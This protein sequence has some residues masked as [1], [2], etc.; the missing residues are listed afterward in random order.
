MNDSGAKMSFNVT[1]QNIG[2]LEHADIRIGRFTVLAGRNNTGKSTVSK[3]LYSAF[4]AMNANHAL[5]H[6]RGLVDALRRALE[7]IEWWPH[8]DQ[9]ADLRPPWAFLQEELH[10]MEVQIRGC[11]IDNVEELDAQMPSLRSSVKAMFDSYLKECPR[12][13]QELKQ[14]G[15]YE[16]EP[17]QIENVST[18]I[19]RALQSLRDD[20]EELSGLKFVVNGLQEKIHQ[21]LLQNFQV[22]DLASLKAQPNALGK[23]VIDGVASYELHR[24]NIT[25]DMRMGGL[26]RLQRYSRVL[27]LESPVHW[28]LKLALETSRFSP[29]FFHIFGKQRIS[30]VPAYVYDLFLALGE[31]YAGEVP[32]QKL[33]EKLTSNR[34]M[35]GKL[36]ISETGELHFLEQNRNIPLSMT[37]MGVINLGILALLMER[38]VLDSGT[39]LFIDEPESCLH[40]TWQHIM[41]DVLF[42]L[43]R[44]GVNV[45]IATH[46]PDILKCVQ[47]YLKKNPDQRHLMAVNRFPPSPTDNDDTLEVMLENIQQE[48][49]EPYADKYFESV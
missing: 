3:L 44:Y 1:I 29:R 7:S 36:S 47:V 32:F 9:Q 40:P 20:F 14:S 49:T 4:D 19:E 10:K 31:E 6:F 27:Y 37:A 26:R 34:V 25:F 18:R 16:F 17:E 39:F 8:D 45:V 30:G 42:E 38:R 33:Y 22:P 41:A 28:K 21:N 13:K 48:L 11:A 35:G 23:I 12:I 15:F 24:E 2:K 46:S 5:S 43:S